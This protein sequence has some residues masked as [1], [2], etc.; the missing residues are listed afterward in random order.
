MVTLR[1]VVSPA[2]I[3][4]PVSRSTTVQP[5]NENDTVYSPAGIACSR[6][7]PVELVNPPTATLPSCRSTST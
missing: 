6:Y 1:L 4:I 7:A 2:A 3:V 5:G